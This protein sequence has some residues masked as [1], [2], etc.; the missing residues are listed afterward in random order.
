M[1]LKKIGWE[2]VDWIDLA[3]NKNKWRGDCEHGDQ[4]AGST[5][6]GKLLE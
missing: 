4:S 1:E 5:E 2:V 6:C 3:K